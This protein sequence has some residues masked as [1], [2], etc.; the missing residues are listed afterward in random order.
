MNFCQRAIPLDRPQQGQFW[1]YTH[2]YYAQVLYTLG[3]DRHAKLRPDLAAAEEKEPNRK[4]LLKWSRYRDAIFGAI[5]ARQG[6]DG[7]WNEGFIGPVYATSMYLTIL[8]LDK[9]TLPIYQR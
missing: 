9:A 4:R 5:C 3:E 2:Y 8:Q 6:S 7:S 1:E